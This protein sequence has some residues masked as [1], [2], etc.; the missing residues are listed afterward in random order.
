MSSCSSRRARTRLPLSAR[1]RSSRRRAPCTRLSTSRR[2][3]SSSWAC[4]MSPLSSAPTAWVR[5]SA[6]RRRRRAANSCSS[7]D[8]RCSRP[9]LSKRSSASTS[10]ECAFRTR[11]SPSSISFAT[12]APFAPSSSQ[13]SRRW[14]RLPSGPRSTWSSI[15]AGT[16]TRRMVSVS[17][18][19]R[20]RSRQ[21]TAI[22][23]PATRPGSAMC[24]RTRATF[25]TNAMA[26]FLSPPERPSSTGPTCTLAIS[27]RSPVRI[28]TLSTGLPWTTSS[29]CLWKRA[30]LCSST[31]TR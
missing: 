5:L 17:S 23:R 11:S 16:K 3:P 29:L 27:A 8:A 1:A 14:P 30:T 31:I 10:A 7:M 13:S 2:A 28:L 22:P 4:T 24:T 12:L 6:L 26:S 9:S 15:C 25:A 18:P 19:S 20:R 21:S